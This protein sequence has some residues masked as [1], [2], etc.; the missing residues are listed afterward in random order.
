M[1]YFIRYSLGICGTETADVVET[2]HPLDSAIYLVNDWAQSFG[3][4]PIE[5]EE[6]ENEEGEVVSLEYE[7]EEYDPEKHDMYL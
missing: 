7:Y 5:G 4:E 1:K 2:Q 6:A 3:Y